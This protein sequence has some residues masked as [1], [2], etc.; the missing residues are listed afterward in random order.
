MF[1]KSVSLVAA[2]AL[3]GVA[4]APAPA[5]AAGMNTVKQIAA[6]GQDA[7]AVLDSGRVRVSSSS[8]LAVTP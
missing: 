3:V 6:P 1:R 2:I 5:S 8:G 7:P 4:A